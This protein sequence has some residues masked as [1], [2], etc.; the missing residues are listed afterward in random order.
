MKRNAITLP[1]APGPSR[2]GC[3]PLHVWFGFESIPIGVATVSH[4]PNGFVEVS[5]RTS[6]M[7]IVTYAY[8]V[9][10]ERKDSAWAAA[11][12]AF[13]EATKVQGHIEWS[14][15]SLKK[16]NNETK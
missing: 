1:L 13:T 16:A 3:Y 15:D 10:F 5:M 6:D 9:E 11:M 12:A 14:D 2:P 7:S 4:L 8:R